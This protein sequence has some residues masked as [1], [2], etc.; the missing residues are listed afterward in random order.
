VLHTGTFTRAA[1]LLAEIVSEASQLASTAVE[2]HLEAAGALST[3]MEATSNADDDDS[4][5]MDGRSGRSRDVSAAV[6]ATP[7]ALQNAS[8]RVGRGFGVL[9][10]RF[11]HGGSNP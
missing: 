1:F 7:E 9:R 6:N 11:H 4:A 3:T 10:G 2:A 8:T 5:V